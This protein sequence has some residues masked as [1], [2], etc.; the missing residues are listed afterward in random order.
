MIL[1]CEQVAAILVD[2]DNWL[3]VTSQLYL[4]HIEFFRFE[5]NLNIFVKL[6]EGIMTTS[7]TL[8]YQ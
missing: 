5:V 6:A 7:A 8:H 3:L 4:I 2:I 1:K